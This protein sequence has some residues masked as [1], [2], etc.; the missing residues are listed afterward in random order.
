MGALEYNSSLNLSNQNAFNGE[1]ET[2]LRLTSLYLI[3]RCCQVNTN[4]R[5]SEFITTQVVILPYYH[6]VAL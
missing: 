4:H 1:E 2:W 5:P 3:T 6:I